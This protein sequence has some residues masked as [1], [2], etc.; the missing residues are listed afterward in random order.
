M[1]LAGNPGGA[2]H[3]ALAERYVTGRTPWAPFE[4]ADQRWVYAPSTV[5]DNP[6]LPEAYKRNFEVL[7]HTD[8]ALYKAHRHGDWSEIGRAHV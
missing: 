4:F 7:R 5:D 2:N 1:I 6:H 8:P 3:S